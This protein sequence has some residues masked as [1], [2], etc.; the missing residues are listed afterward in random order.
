MKLDPCHQFPDQNLLQ[1]QFPLSFFP[2]FMAVGKAHDDELHHQNFTSSNHHQRHLLL[3][4][5][6]TSV[7]MIIVCFKMD[8]HPHDPENSLQRSSFEV[9]GYSKWFKHMVQTKKKVIFQNMFQH[10]GR[11][12]DRNSKRAKEEQKTTNLTL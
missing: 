1:K 12:A 2:E 7:P 9:I 3:Y 11:I 6:K 4:Q 8:H 5:G 10:R